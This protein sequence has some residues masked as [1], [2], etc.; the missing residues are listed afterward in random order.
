MRLLSLI[1]ALAI[2]VGLAAQIMRG[3]RTRP[4]FTDHFSSLLI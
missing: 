4:D 2:V 3:I 1:G